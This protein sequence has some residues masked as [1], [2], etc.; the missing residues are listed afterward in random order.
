MVM[1]TTFGSRAHYSCD[2]GYTLL[3]SVTRTCESDGRWSGSDPRC[4][5]KYTMRY[6][7]KRE[8]ITDTFYEAKLLN[9][10]KQFDLLREE[11]TAYNEGP[12]Q[13][14]HI[15]RSDKTSINIV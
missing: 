10:E 1:G 14:V 7:T 8:R 5:G 13:Y 2:P 9:L 6:K 3:G 15:H 12:Q 4:S 11:Q